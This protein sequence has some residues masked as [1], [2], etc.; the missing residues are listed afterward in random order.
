MS[1]SIYRQ[2]APLIPSPRLPQG[3]T[4]VSRDVLYADKEQLFP[5]K[6]K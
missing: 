5:W 6:P 1:P 3:Q 4:K 2:Q